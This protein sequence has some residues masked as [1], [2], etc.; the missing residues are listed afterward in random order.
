LVPLEFFL[1]NFISDKKKA[2]KKFHHTLLKI[3]FYNLIGINVEIFWMHYIFLKNQFYAKMTKKKSKILQK[4]H[5]AK[6]IGRFDFFLNKNRG[7]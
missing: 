6:T 5:F 2:F 4:P 1:L 7:K 3:S